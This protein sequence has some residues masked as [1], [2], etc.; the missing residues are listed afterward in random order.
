MPKLI[1]EAIRSILREAFVLN[2]RCSGY[3]TWKLQA[4]EN[5]RRHL[6]GFTPE[7]IE[8]LIYRHVEANGEI[9]FAK[10]TRDEW[11]DYGY[12]YDFV[13]VVPDQFRIYVETVIIRA[14]IHDPGVHIVNCHQAD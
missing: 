13:L 14:N 2:Q 10:E 9:K 6:P 8:D 4:Q 12:H 5:V 3:V 1:D 7:A 11:L